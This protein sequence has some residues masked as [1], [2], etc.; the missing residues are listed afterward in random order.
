MNTKQSTTQATSWAGKMGKAYTDRNPQSIKELNALYK[1]Q[2]GTSRT[3]MNRDFLGDLD[4]N[5]KIF[6]VGANIGLQL[7]TLRKIGFHNLFGIELNEYA[8]MQAKRIHPAVD[9][10]KGSA[11]DLPFRDACF[12]FVF[13]SGVLIH[14]SPKDITKALDEIWR[15]SSR[16]VWGFEYFAEHPTEVVYRGKKN[17]LWKR[18]FAALYLQRFSSAKLIKEQ[19]FSLKGSENVSQMFLLKK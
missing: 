19:K 12:D 11:F 13:T 5:I 6:E 1:K 10:I 16:Y 9:I 4:R 2:Y 17:L 14:I 8:V 3:L 18:D 7:E 15:V